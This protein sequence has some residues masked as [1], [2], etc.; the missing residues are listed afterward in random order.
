MWIHLLRQRLFKMCCCALERAYIASKRVRN[1][2]RDFMYYKATPIY[3]RSW[4]NVSMYMNFALHKASLDIYWAL[5]ECKIINC[6]LRIL[7]T[8]PFSNANSFNQDTTSSYSDESISSDNSNKHIAKP[9]GIYNR[10]WYQ[11]KVIMQHKP[12]F[13]SK[14]NHDVKKLHQVDNPIN[15]NSV[16]TKCVSR[17][18]LD[19]INFSYFNRK[20]TWIEA[21]LLDLEIAKRQ[22]WVYNTVGCLN[23]LKS[24]NI[25]SLLEPKSRAY[26]FI[27]LIPQSITHSLIRFKTELVANYNAFML[28]E[29]RLAKYLAVSSLQYMAW[30]LLL[31]WLLC[32]VCKLIILQPLAAYWW[33]TDQF[34]V[35]TNISQEQHAFRHLQEIE[36]LLWL[37]IVISDASHKSP[38]A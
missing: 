32:N 26:E 38:Q 13:I 16:S 29:F 33:N 28:I 25:L 37:D 35:F 7:N 3:T 6:V 1:I 19:M 24:S 27:G 22:C 2:Q 15:V 11:T 10:N 36:E 14:P 30:L 8:D 4:Y 5:V 23:L 9:Q 31:P 20:I 17:Y 18:V 21:T 34:Q 12:I